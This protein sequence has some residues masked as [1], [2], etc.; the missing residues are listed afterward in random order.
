MDTICSG[1]SW[2][3][4][5]KGWNWCAQDQNGDWYWY[6]VRPEP[7]IGGGVWRSNSRHQRF[8]GHGHP[9]NNWHCSLQYRQTTT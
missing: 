4:A 5:P 1:P 9:N 3:L 2:D 8:A 6:Y 7:S